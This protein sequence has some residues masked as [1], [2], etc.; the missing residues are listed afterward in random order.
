[1]LEGLIEDHRQAGHQRLD[2]VDAARFRA[3]V[4]IMPP[5]PATVLDVGCGVG[6]LTDWLVSEGYDA[7]GVDSDRHLMTRMVAPHRVASI[8]ALPFEASSFDAV[9]ASEVL[10]HLP[11]GAYTR[12][13]PELVRVSRRTIIITVPNGE[14]LESATTRCPACGCVFSIHGH[15]RRFDAQ[16]MTRLLPG[17]RLVQL[18][19]VGPWKVRHRSI[20]WV[21]RRRLMANWPRQPGAVCPQCHYRQSSGEGQDRTLQRSLVRAARTVLGFPWRHR[22]TLVARYD[23]D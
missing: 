9:V 2:S 7:T 8:D 11:V 1:M 19:E 16:D 20:E 15:V 10:E 13:L 12:A 17:A 6:V 3:I 18:S 5:P 22:W 23:V 4:A 21:L 14:S